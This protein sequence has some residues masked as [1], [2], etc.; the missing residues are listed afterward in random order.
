[1]FYGSLTK[2]FACFFANVNIDVHPVCLTCTTITDIGKVVGNIPKYQKVGID[3][4]AV[5]KVVYIKDQRY[6]YSSS[7]TTGTD[8]W[9]VNALHYR[10]SLD[11]FKQSVEQEADKEKGK[12]NTKID[13]QEYV[14]LQS[15][16][17]V[18]ETLFT[19]FANARR[20]L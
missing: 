3:A 12:G 2:T 4:N 20:A 16:I 5:R 11:R 14:Q 13:L 6:S 15:N 17:Q 8:D 1:M 18:S 19:I 7:T 9:F 10:L